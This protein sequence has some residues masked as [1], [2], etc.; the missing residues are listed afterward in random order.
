[1]DL[2]QIFK[3][4]NPI[5]GVVHLQ[6]LPTSPRWSGNLKAIIGRAEQEAT[7]LASGGANGI[8]VENFFDAPFAKVW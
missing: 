3:T 1:V 7:A 4:P 5:I 2:K 6:P 8:I